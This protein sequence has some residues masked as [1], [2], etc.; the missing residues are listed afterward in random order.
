M[1]ARQNHPHRLARWLGNVLLGLVLTP[2]AGVVQAEL[3]SPT[4]LILKDGRIASVSVHVL[5]FSAGQAAIG[6]AASR[7]LVDLTRRMATDCFLTAQV[8]GH[9]GS[10]EVKSS[11]T[12]GAH[13]LARSR[14]DAVQASLIDTGLP[15]KSIA[16]VWDW[17]F[18]VLEPRATLWVFE[19]TR[20]E[21]CEGKPLEGV[22]ASVAAA[23]PATRLS[24]GERPGRPSDVA[25]SPRSSGPSPGSTVSAAAEP[26]PLTTPA[27][28]ASSARAAPSAVEPRPA[29]APASTA[30]DAPETSRTRATR[31][32]REVA[33]AAPETSTGSA[34]ARS[35]SIVFANNSSY[36]PPGTRKQ[37]EALIGGLASGGRYRVEITASVSDA[38]SVVGA[39]NSEEA[40]RYNQWLAN[41]RL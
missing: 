25:A 1:S 21:D 36:F 30:L 18:M 35:L 6:S 37:L 9:V 2:W 7:S 26:T 24:A 16:S 23:E 38:S 11:D 32:T 15:A 20:G 33:R 5:P 3:L 27:R 17:Q 14:A 8:I 12:L 19:L 10:E 13:R 22:V 28:A 39:A 40:A 29:A 34:E 31:P 4:P 41:R